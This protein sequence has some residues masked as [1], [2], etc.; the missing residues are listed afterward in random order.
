MGDAVNSSTA[1]PSTAPPDAS[2]GARQQPQQLDGGV[3]GGLS[4]GVMAA[5]EIM[6]GELKRATAGDST[7]AMAWDYR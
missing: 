4:A 3:G 7:S 5:S 2:G 6:R 1:R